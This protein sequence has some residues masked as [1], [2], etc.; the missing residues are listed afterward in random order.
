MRTWISGRLP[1]DTLL[2]FA[3]G[4]V[5][6]AI[7]IVLEVLLGGDEARLTIRVTL[8]LAAAGIGAGIPG[9]L[10]FQ[11]S[12]GKGL[13]IKGSG[14]LVF[15][16]VVYLINPLSS[17]PKTVPDIEE[18]TVHPLNIMP[19]QMVTIV[20][21]AR[22]ADVV[23]LRPLNQEWRNDQSVSASV[24]TSPITDTT[25]M[26]ELLINGA[27]VAT[28]EAS[29]VVSLPVC[30]ARGEQVSLRTGPGE[31]FP[32]AARL[33][34]RIKLAPIDYS[35]LEYQPDG[36]VIRSEWLH[37]RWEGDD[38]E[39]W[40]PTADLDCPSGTLG[41][42]PIA[43]PPPTP[44]VTPT[45]TS[46]PTAT[47]TQTPTSSPTP[48]P[49]TT[50]TP[51]PPKILSF[52]VSP[53]EVVPGQVVLIT[54]AF[55][56]ADQAELLAS[57]AQNGTPPELLP[58]GGG[59]VVPRD[60]AD[61]VQHRPAQATTYE[62]ILRDTAGAVQAKRRSRVEVVAPECVV[63]TTNPYENLQLRSGPGTLYAPVPS[64]RNSDLPVLLP[65]GTRVTALGYT[66]PSGLEQGGVAFTWIKIEYQT[67]EG[68]QEGWVAWTFLKCAVE[69]AL[70]PRIPKEEWPPTPTPRAQATPTAT[71]SPTATS[72]PPLPPAPPATPQ[73]PAVFGPY[74]VISGGA[75]GCT[76]WQRSFQLPDAR[77]VLDT[78]QGDGRGYALVVTHQQPLGSLGPG[79]I[80]QLGGMREPV[81]ETTI[82]ANGREE[83]RVTVPVCPTRLVERSSPFGGS[84]ARWVD[85]L[86]VF[87]VHLFGRFP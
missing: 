61:Q 18:F 22:N 19:G 66:P 87:E 51:P 3:F 45:A 74:Q 4:V 49:T 52:S 31:R 56:N 9:L 60:L 69:Y 15:F 72:V 62:L 46:T 26:L 30:T 40:A 78:S 32:E 58:I 34:K 79:T 55:E 81:L 16:L 2:A 48:T 37:L 33:N 50:S 42:L 82:G 36:R 41:V 53:T 77:M 65:N 27:P 76:V 29:V 71:P 83:V 35:P 80:E 63:N 54:F 73:P 21:R 68:L 86:A 43:T 75:A 20:W 70:L 12:S 39:G 64:E 23:R 14:A 85:H 11:A 57:A 44:T 17:Q 84:R 6:L 10:N 38:S 8:A 47:A 7:T 5:F 25:Y 59:D 13:A 24:T 1:I 28:R 67:S